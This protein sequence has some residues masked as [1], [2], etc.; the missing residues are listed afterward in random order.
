MSF[1]IIPLTFFG[2]FFHFSI[3]N[4]NINILFA[5]S[6]TILFSTLLSI[7]QFSFFEIYSRHIKVDKKF[8]KFIFA[9]LFPTTIKVK[10]LT[11]LS[12]FFLIL[13]ILAYKFPINLEFFNEIYKI[14]FLEIGN[15]CNYLHQKTGFNFDYFLFSAV[16]TLNASIILI[17]RT[18]ERWGL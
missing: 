8:H 12:I 9:K 14:E 16:N 18:I 10:S 17:L 15:F 2:S 13:S 7:N 11:F 4:F 1:F 6:F 5:F 3:L